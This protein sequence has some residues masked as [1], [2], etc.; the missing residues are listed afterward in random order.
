[1]FMNKNFLKKLRENYSYKILWIHTSGFYCVIMNVNDA[2]RD[3][4]K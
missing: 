3:I 4:S 2:S 1:M